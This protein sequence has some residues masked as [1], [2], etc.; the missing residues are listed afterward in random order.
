MTGKDS[1]PVSTEKWSKLRADAQI[2]TLLG[3]THIETTIIYTHVQA[4][5]DGVRSPLDLLEVSEG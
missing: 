3:H 4:G 2:Q 5:S 1:A